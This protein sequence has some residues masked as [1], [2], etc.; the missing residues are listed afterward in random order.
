MEN[1]YVLSSAGCS[2]GFFCPGA[3]DLPGITACFSYVL[4][5]TIREYP[6]GGLAGEFKKA[7]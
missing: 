5:G 4:P 3:F 7:D 2:D 1:L 6:A